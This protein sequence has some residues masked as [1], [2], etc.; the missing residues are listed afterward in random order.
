MPFPDPSDCLITA[1]AVLL[2]VPLVT[3]DEIT[4][5]GTVEVLS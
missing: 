2:E 1:T 5:A 3:S 4:S